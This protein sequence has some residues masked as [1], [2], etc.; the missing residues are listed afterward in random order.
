[1]VVVHTSFHIFDLYP[2]TLGLE[3]S[4]SY[5]LLLQ[6]KNVPRNCV[7]ATDSRSCANN[8]VL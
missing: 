2:D 3:M 8:I 6:G 7:P 5:D 1:M 4:F